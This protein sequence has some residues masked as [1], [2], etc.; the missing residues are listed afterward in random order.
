MI[1]V[2]GAPPAD[3]SPK[4]GGVVGMEHMA[5][6]MDH[7]VIQHFRRSHDDAPIIVDGSAG[8]AT[9]PA[10]FLIPQADPVRIHADLCGPI[11]GAFQQMVLRLL[12]VPLLQRPI[13]VGIVILPDKL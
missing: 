11:A 12:C 13:D 7:E 2:V 3:F 5:Q 10:G 8:G 1:P 9:A 6:F 4:S